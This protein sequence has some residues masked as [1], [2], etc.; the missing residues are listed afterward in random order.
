VTPS[1]R[2]KSGEDTVRD[3]NQ[4]APQSRRSVLRLLGLAGCAAAGLPLLVGCRPDESAVVGGPVTVERAEL[5][6]AGRL[7]V[8]WQGQPVELR[9]TDQ[10][11]EA[12]SLLCTHMGCSVYWDEAR[13]GYYCPCHKGV[14]N[15]RGEPIEGPPQAALRSVP[16]QVTDTTVVIGA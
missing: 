13:D 3:D 15:A 10:G 6:G 16:V 9:L 1:R 8:E 11:V 7:T 5:E 14:F 4:D 2:A 12:R